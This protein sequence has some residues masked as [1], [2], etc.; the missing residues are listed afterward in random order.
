[1]DQHMTDHWKNYECEPAACVC[2]TGCG[3]SVRDMR[4]FLSLLRINAN[5]LNATAHVCV[6]G[7]HRHTAAGPYK[8]IRCQKSWMTL[9]CWD[10][11]IIFS[12]ARD[13]DAEKGK[14]ELMVPGRHTLRQTES[15]FR[16]GSWIH[17][18][19]SSFISETVLFLLW[20][21]LKYGQWRL[22]WQVNSF[23]KIPHPNAA[24]L[25]FP[26]RHS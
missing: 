14:S 5:L 1:M 11:L 6:C 15:W 23:I 25:K 12:P 3:F 22:F 18:T 8:E 13:S 21:Q 17:C 26:L 24:R 19:Q 16:C 2:E 4:G 20:L 9:F 7:Q 10:S